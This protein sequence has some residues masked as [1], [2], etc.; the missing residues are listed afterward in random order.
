MSSSK[1]RSSPERKPFLAGYKQFIINQLTTQDNMGC[2]VGI[3]LW[4]AGNGVHSPLQPTFLWY[5]SDYEV[6]IVT[7]KKIIVQFTML[8]FCIAGLA[9]GTLIILG[10]FGFRIHSSVLES[11]QHLE[12]NL[13]FALYILSPAI[14]SYIILKRNNKIAGIKEWLKTVFYIKTTIIP[15]FFAVAVLA[16]FFLIHI[17][18]SG[19]T[20]MMLPFYMFFLALPGNLIIGGLEEAGWTYLLHPGLE[21]KYGFVRSS[22][23][24]GVIWLSWHIPLFFIPGT[25][26]AEGNID[27]WMFAVQ[28]MAFRFLYGAVYKISG[29]G[30]VF[31]C[32][33]SHTMFN[34]AS[35]SFGVP[36]TTWAGTIAAN[37]MVI[38]VSI[39]TVV[40]YDKKNSQR[41]KASDGKAQDV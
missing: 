24:V 19:P 41:V 27:F 8:T 6:K 7:D 29:K 12:T 23:Y 3:E 20:E 25:G 11:I 4:L 21:K 1:T 38:L 15:Y 28:I 30:Y 18:V 35:Y 5:T 9:S 14:A 16:L 39:V 37:A 36:P 17:V 40:I 26:H 2:L 32:V 22:L 34:A 31:M 33:L 10:Q 13:P